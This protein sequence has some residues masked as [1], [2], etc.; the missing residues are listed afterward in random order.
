[1]ERGAVIVFMRKGR[2]WLDAVPELERYHSRYEVKNFQ[3]PAISRENC[4]GFEK[5][6]QAIEVAETKRRESGQRDNLPSATQAWS[7]SCPRRPS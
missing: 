2:A 3:N 7:W 6:V 4:G 1:M 5:V